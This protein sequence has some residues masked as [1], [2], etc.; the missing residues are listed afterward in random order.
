M[1]NDLVTDINDIHPKDKKDVGLRLA[2][3]ALA[4]TYG[5]KELLIKAR[6]YKSMNIEKGKSK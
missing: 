4:E 2:N 1:I 5:K 6:M 3:Y